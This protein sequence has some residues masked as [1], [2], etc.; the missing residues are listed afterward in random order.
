MI[1]PAACRDEDPELFFPV[2]D[3][4][5]ARAHTAETT[6]LRGNPSD[7]KELALPHA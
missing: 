1:G 6:G 7:L 3:S 4:A 5:P 2:G